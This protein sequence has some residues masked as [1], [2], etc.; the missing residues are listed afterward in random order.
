ME[1]LHAELAAVRVV[2]TDP[3]ASVRL[4]LTPEAVVVAEARRTLTSLA[5]Y[6]YRTDAVIA[7]RVFPQAYSPGDLVA[8]IGMGLTLFW[9]SR[10]RVLAIR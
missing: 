7:N 5:L 3:G 8:I 6:G 2:L 4:V 1:R 9:S 10:R